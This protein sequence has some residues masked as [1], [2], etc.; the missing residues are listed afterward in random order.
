MQPS[1]LLSAGRRLGFSKLGGH[2]DLPSELAWP[3]GPEWLPATGRIYAFHSEDNGS[4]DQVRIL[5]APAERSV[6]EAQP[7]DASAWPYDEQPIAFVLRDSFP[8]LDWLAEDVTV[9]EAELDG[10]VGLSGPDWDGPPH[11]L[12]G[13]PD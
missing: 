5:Y 2:P 6:A 10:L 8:S 13:Y 4:P 3:E 12:G 9:D 7:R 11:K 1:L